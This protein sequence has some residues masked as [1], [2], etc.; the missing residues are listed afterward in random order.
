M[1]LRTLDLAVLVLYVAGV[2]GLGCWFVR[3]SRTTAEFMKAGGSLPS[4]AVGLS[5]FGT[6]LS[7]ITFLGVPGKAYAGDWNAFVFSLT[8][9]PAAWLAVKYFVP[10]YRR[11]GEISA[12]EHFEQR[13]GGWARTYAV[14]CYLLTQ[15]GRIGSILFGVALALNALLGWPVVWIIVVTGVLVTAYTLLG[16]IEAVIWTDVVQS[17]VLSV[18]AL[19]VVGV[20]LVEMPGGPQTIFSIGGAESKFSLGAFDADLTT[21]T[22]WVVLVYG[23]FINLTNFG[24]DQNYVQR[25]HAARTETAAGRSVWLA[26][27]L[28]PPVALVFFF[29]GTALFAYYESQ[30]EL[31][32]PV[33]AAAAQTKLRSL[34]FAVDHSPSG[35]ADEQPG[36]AAAAP[37]GGSNPTAAEPSPRDSEVRE[38]AAAF[39]PAD[40]GDRVF[41]HFIAT[42]LPPGLAGLLIAALFAAAMSTVDTSLNSSATVILTDLYRRYARPDAGEREQMR[43]LYAATLVMGVVGTGGA[44]AMIGIQSILDAWWTLSGVFAGG[45]LGLFLL[46]MIARQAHAAAAAVGVVCGLLVICWMTFSASP[47]L[48]LPPELRSPFHTNL[49]IVFGTVTIFTVGVLVSAIWPRGRGSR[50]PV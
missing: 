24:I 47:V 39:G 40:Y 30:P 9:P 28:Y 1:Q 43:A 49:I 6:F 5:L 25:Y 10:F 14:V 26:A 27:L 37:G 32:D 44:V 34:T 2:V 31:L 35:A 36:D 29:I 23:L 33:R 17:L 50:S 20:L 13:F 11:R 16:G 41:P 42:R 8:L 48:N 22:F 3:S 46:G 4:W 19:V 12:Y 45:L 15:L 7:S 38:L 21:S 18:G